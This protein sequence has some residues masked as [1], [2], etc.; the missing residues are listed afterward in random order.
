MAIVISQKAPPPPPHRH[1]HPD[2]LRT[3]F[4][5]YL[6]PILVPRSLCADWT[7]CIL[8]LSPWPLTLLC[9]RLPF[10]SLSFLL[11]FFLSFFLSFFLYF[12][13]FRATPATYGSSQARGRIGVTAASLLHSHSK[14]GS[15]LHLLPT[16]ELTATPDPEST[17]QGQGSNGHP[18]GS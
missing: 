18:Y 10:W 14:T 4:P 11:F 17:E 1:S 12:L 13:L 8:P 7:P 9:K 2:P 15:E 16:P 6:C 5:R 3:G